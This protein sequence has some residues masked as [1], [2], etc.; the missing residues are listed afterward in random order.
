MKNIMI[1]ISIWLFRKAYGLNKI[2]LR[3]GNNK[4]VQQNY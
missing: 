2:K 1:K 4:W 3:G